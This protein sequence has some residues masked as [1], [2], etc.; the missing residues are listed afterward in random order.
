MHTAC[1][2]QHYSMCRKA[3]GC[4]VVAPHGSHANCHANVFCEQTPHPVAEQVAD[5]CRSC[6]A[7]HSALIMIMVPLQHAL[8]QGCGQAE[9]GLQHDPSWRV[10]TLY[11][12]RAPPAGR[13]APAAA[14]QTQQCSLRW[15]T[16]AQNSK[17]SRFSKGSMSNQV[18][19]TSVIATARANTTQ[20]SMEVVF[21]LRVCLQAR[22][23]GNTGYIC[24]P[25]AAL[26]H[27]VV[28]L[29]ALPR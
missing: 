3:V 25:G 21:L 19:A 4:A 2:R 7:A 12:S 11:G 8:F 27:A 13:H 28:Q 9:A 20:A 24:Q 26:L 23:G 16:S 18:L 22:S 5:C 6:R 29:L 15:H 10:A 14:Q 1:H 17:G